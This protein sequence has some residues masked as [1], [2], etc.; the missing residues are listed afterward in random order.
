MG[1]STGVD[2]GFIVVDVQVR[3]ATRWDLD[4][5]VYE[6]G[7]RTGHYESYYQRANHPSRPLAFWIRY[8]VFAPAGRPADA[9]GDLWAVF[10]DGES[11]RHTVAKTQFPIE[12]CRFARDTFDVRVDEATLSPGRLQGR[13]GEVGWD[14]DYTVTAEP[15]LLF[16]DSLYEGG[17]PKAKTLIPAPLAVFTGRLTVEGCGVDIDG[18]VGSQNHNWGSR[19]TDRYAY[20]QV[21]G[22]DNDP[23]A[24]LDVATAKPVLAGPV[25]LPWFTFVVLRHQGQEHRCS[26]LLHGLRATAS[27]RFFDWAFSARTE[28]VDLHGHITAPIESFVGLRYPNPPGGAKQCLNTKIGAAEVIVTD[29]RSGRA[30]RLNTDR[31]ALFEILTDDDTHGVALRA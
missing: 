25:S 29:R 4:R 21:A 30:T 27:Y 8:T 11:N 2:G 14:L 7:Q 22:F 17:F 26:S 19:H 13:A 15:M 6:P 28:S 1:A 3:S 18:W 24:F 31:R 20:G 12:R 23:D 9:V 16:D 5:A 10:F